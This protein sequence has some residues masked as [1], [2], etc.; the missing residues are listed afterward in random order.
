MDIIIWLGI[1]VIVILV[2]WYLIKQVPLPGPANQ[3]VEIA[4][5]IIVAAVVIGFL[6]S[7]SG[8]GF[9]LPR[10]TR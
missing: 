10:I 7:F 2:V 6:L 8:D 3:I 5:V 9:K 4:I 1:A